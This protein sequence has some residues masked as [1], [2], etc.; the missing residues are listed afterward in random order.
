M[1]RHNIFVFAWRA[2][3]FAVVW[4]ILTDGAPDGWWAGTVMAPLAAAISVAL[5][6][7]AP[8]SCAA[9]LRFI[10]F[11]VVH[12]LKGGIDVARRVSRPSLDVQPTLFDYVLRLRSAN[13]CVFMSGVVSLLPGT[14]A[15]EL[16]GRRLRVHALD[17][18]DTFLAELELLERHVAALFKAHTDDP[19]G[20]PRP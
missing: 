12:S 7:A 5:R 3:G 14:L 16:D 1:N 10:P 13:A 20:E 18:R 9:L 15:A 11:F 8:W 2:A 17:T 19:A 4:W 6:P